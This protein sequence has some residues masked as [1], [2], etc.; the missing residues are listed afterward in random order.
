MSFRAASDS[1]YIAQL[2]GRMVR[3]PLARRIIDDEVL[4][5]V[6][7]YLP[8]YDTKGLERIVSRL[9]KPDEGMPP[10]DVELSEDVIELNKSANSDGAF[11]A[12]GMIPSYVVPRKRKASQVRRLMKFARLLTNDDLDGNALS[13]AKSKLL[14]VLNKEYARSKND[15]RFNEI[16]EGKRLIEIEAVN[17]DVGS[18]TTSDGETIKVD[19]ASEN[20]EDLFEASGRK[21]NE[22]LHKAWWRARVSRFPDDREKAKLELFALCADPDVMRKIEKEAQ[23]TVQS[24][25]QKFRTAIAKLDEKSRAAYD[26]IRNLAASPELSP[27]VFPATLQGHSADKTWKKHL[28]VNE[29]KVFPAEFNEPEREILTR[30]LAA[31]DVVAWLRNIDRRPWALCVPYEV[32]GEIRSMYPDFLIVRSEGEGL[33]VDVIDPHTISLADAPAKAAG[34]AKFASQHADKFGRIELIMLDGNTSK[35]LELTDE[36]VRNKVRGITLPNQLRQLFE[37]S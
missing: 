9:S 33:V 20:V 16:V 4:N 5:T 2:V 19:I 35:R 14:A 23:D 24:W 36:T 37:A 8:H 32:D 12:L 10:V 30:E 13:S 28:Y 25:L 22:G 11:Q 6:A 29:A 18:D 1:T 21:L 27:L 26:E 3:S 34:L 7:L 17:W 31:K 15:T